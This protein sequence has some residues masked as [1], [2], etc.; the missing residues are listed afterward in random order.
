[1]SRNKPYTTNQE[2]WNTIFQKK[3]RIPMN[4]REYSWE[5]KEIFKFLDDIFK[6][7]EEDKYVLKMGSIINLNYNGGN[8]IYDGQQRILT[9]IL[10]LN[11][12]GC[13]LPKLK[14]KINNLLTV[15]T[16]IDYLTKEQE[17]IK[18]RC[19]V[20][21]IP[22]I[23]CINP[24]DMEGLVNIFNNKIK[25]WVEYVDIID[26]FDLLDEDEEYCC[27]V[28]KTTAAK[29]FDFKRHIVS[30]HG[31]IP[32]TTNTKIH[33]AFIEIYNYFVLKKYNENS[34]VN[35]YKFILHDIDVQYYDC[36]DPEYVSRIFDWENNRGKA[37]ENLDIIK[38]PILVKIPDDRKVE[39][40]ERWESLKHTPNNIY[41]KNFGQ[42]IFDVAIQIY[43]NEIKRT[44]NHEESFKHIIDSKDT[45]KE[46]N[47]FFQIVEK[48]FSIMDKITHDKF[49]KLLNNTSRICLNC[50]AYMW[51]LLPI[52]YTKRI[53]DTK[54]IKLMTKWYFRNLQFKNRSFNNMCYSSEFIRITNALLKDNDF[55]YYTEIEICL[56]KNKDNSITDENYLRELSLM[57]FKSTNATYLLLFY[58]TCI[59]TDLQIVSL[60]YTLE[61]I[62]SQKDKANLANQS[63]MNNIGN[64]TLIEG[65]N[66]DNGHKGNSSIGCKLYDKKQ[67]SY[68]ES[69]SK[70]TRNIAENYKT[71]EE[72]DIIERNKFI[73]IKLNEFTNY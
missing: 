1:M 57:N 54:L 5:E 13:L 3:L 68:S 26:D 49:G 19:N 12:I 25:S 53:I 47:I 33:S 36:N 40:Y 43:N 37:V 4:Q 38:N 52:F 23:S 30:K 34:L 22:K 15:D 31:Y 29:K 39:V 63:L 20:N 18:E 66:S 59:N 28:C 67:N 46:I 21:I 44:I 32:P 70:I 9:T 62:Y 41:K 27:K 72:K 24:F 60:E 58:E 61:H 65:K 45:Y 7:Y 64:L 50:E 73:S 35:L 17:Q 6:I 14:G 42:K 11:V 8:D 69:S 56:K 10:I 16:E 71:F 2:T 51:C 48:L 55:N